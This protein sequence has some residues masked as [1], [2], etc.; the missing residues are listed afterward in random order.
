M[1]ITD[2]L[3]ALL[4]LC[5]GD[6]EYLK[7]IAK[8]ENNTIYFTNGEVLKFNEIDYDGYEMVAITQFKERLK[9]W[10]E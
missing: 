8:I 6:N 4:A 10:K 7:L 9:K 5:D 1:W 3:K 2:I